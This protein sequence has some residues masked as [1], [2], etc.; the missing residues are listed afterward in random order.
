MCAAWTTVAAAQGYVPAMP[1]TTITPVIST[2]PIAFPPPQA[3]AHHALSPINQSLFPVF[4]NYAIGDFNIDGRLDLAV[5]PSYYN[6]HPMLPMVILL[7]QGDGRFA[8]GTATMIEGP[9][10]VC[11]SPNNMFVRDFNGDG[12]I[13]IVIVEQGLEDK[14]SFSPGFDGGLNIALYSQPNGKM[15]D[16]S[17]RAFPGQARRF[18][19]VSSMGDLNGDG[20]LDI[21]LTRLG[22]PTLGLGGLAILMNDGT[23]RFT[24]TLA[25]LPREAA[26]RASMLPGVDYH[27][28]GANGVGDLDGDGRLDLVAATYNFPDIPSKTRTI[29][30][31]GQNGDGNFVERFRLPIPAALAD[32]PYWE[33][34]SASQVL[35]SSGVYIHDFNSDGRNDVLVIWEGAGPTYFTFLRNDG[36]FAFTDVTAQWWGN[37]VSHYPM[38]SSNAKAGAMVAEFRDV[39]G[40][41]VADLYIRRGYIEPAGLNP[42]TLVYLNDGTGRLSPWRWESGGVNASQEA[43]R[44]SIYPYGTYSYFWMDVDGDGV[45]D[46]VYFRYL[47]DFSTT[48]NFSKGIE[49]R[50]YRSTLPARAGTAVK[51]LWWAGSA[52]NGWGMSITQHRDTLFVVFYVYDAQGNPVWYVM[53][54]GSWNA[55][56]TAYSGAIYH[57]RGA[58]FGTYD[59]SR[60]AV[61][62]TVGS[63][64]LTFSSN[65]S[66]TVDYTIGAASGRKAITRQPFAAGPS[67]TRYDDLWWGG[68]AENGWGLNISQ[69]ANTLFAVWYT[70]DAAGVARWYVMPGGTWSGQRYTGR[71]YSTKGSAW[72][73]AAYD[74]SAFV[75]SEAGSL[76]L[77]FLDRD[78]ALATYSVG[79]VQQTKALFRQPF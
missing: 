77:S 17:A 33:G 30:A 37:P 52:E 4:R 23:G 32:I 36:N 7:N 27:S 60:F 64:T 40:D 61:G 2:I 5:C 63:V 73:G 31:Y 54:G 8:D 43:L 57:P 9:V 58:P 44:A 39:N 20:A 11:G 62:N 21:M 3:N 68:A 35:G 10:P 66:A 26:E 79:G 50:A 18:N 25:P 46:P 49:V 12:R 34:G 42:S 76:A 47:D 6:F 13:D 75:A 28:P 14:N 53:P 45:D 78:T 56:R 15:R 59:A 69:Q 65:S 70:Y 16:E 41:G 72:L 1:E 24:E 19:H 67:L 29:R 22:G 51:D 71:L 55:G 74:P 48:P 38:S